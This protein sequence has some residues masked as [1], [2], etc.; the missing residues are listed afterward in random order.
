MLFGKEKVIAMYRTG[1]NYSSGKRMGAIISVTG[2]RG[3]YLI[4]IPDT[5]DGGF[6]IIMHALDN[7]RDVEQKLIR[8]GWKPMVSGEADPILKAYMPVFQALQEGGL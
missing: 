3:F 1:V 7:Y 2:V 5:E 6:A 8:E 4:T